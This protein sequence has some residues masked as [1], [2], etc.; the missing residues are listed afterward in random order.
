MK[1]II[2]TRARAAGVQSEPNGDALII[3]LHWCRWAF[4]LC[5]LTSYIKGN[6]SC[7]NKVSSRLKSEA[8]LESDQARYLQSPGTVS[9]DVHP[10]K[11]TSINTEG[12]NDALARAVNDWTYTFATFAVGAMRL[13][14]RVHSSRRTTSPH[15]AEELPTHLYSSHP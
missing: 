14:L 9:I 5:R 11:V 3:P 12:I 4:I 15:L 8:R 6:L 10:T 1:H 7:L 13:Q 2:I